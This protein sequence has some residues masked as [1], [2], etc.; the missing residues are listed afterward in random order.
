MMERALGIW[1]LA[2]C[3]MLATPAIAQ[4]DA[5]NIAAARQMAYDGIKAY[6]NGNVSRG[7]SLLERA[8]ALVKAP[9]IGLWSARA[10]RESG[11]W[12][13]A[14]ERFLETTRL[15]VPATNRANHQK[16]KKAAAV[17]REELLSKI[18]NLR[19]DVKGAPSSEV[20]LT[21]DGKRVD[22]ALIGA[23][24]PVDPYKHHLVAKWNG[25]EKSAEIYLKEGTTEA[26][27]LTFDE[28][29]SIAPA[30]PAPVVAPEAPKPKPEPPPP[31]VKPKTP[32]PTQ[33]VAPETGSSNTLA[34][35][36]LGVGGVGL[37]AGGITGVIAMGKKKDLDDDAAC[38]DEKC[39]PPAHDQVDSLNSMRT[40]STVGF[41]VGAVGVGVGVTLL[42]SS[43]KRESAKPT[44]LRVGPGWM[45]VA[46]SF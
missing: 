20:E 10:L 32:P 5:E 40:F 9:T 12:I 8:Y 43:P 42:L 27:T 37:V 46:G 3:L 34:Y 29:G 45:S 1:S 30:T 6:E 36:A 16:A 38:A 24:R 4:T 19:V 21:M 18:P 25:Q 44:A 14:S 13:A 41:V 33:D 11:Q 17:E 39:A 28:P 22:S 35:V 31:P 7:R 15:P 26:V 23:A 2:A